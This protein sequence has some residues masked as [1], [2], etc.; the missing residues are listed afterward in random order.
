M[1]W[2]GFCHVGMIVNQIS[3][4]FAFGGTSGEVPARGFSLRSMHVS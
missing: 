2:L 3:I 4:S 1:D